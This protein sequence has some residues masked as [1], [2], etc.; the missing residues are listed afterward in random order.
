MIK[1]RFSVAMEQFY[2][3]CTAIHTKCVEILIVI[4]LFQKC[5]VHHTCLLYS[6]Y[7]AACRLFLGI[8]SRFLRA[9]Q[10]IRSTSK[11]SAAILLFDAS[12]SRRKTVNN[13]VSRYLV[14][15][16]VLPILPLTSMICD[17]EPIGGIYIDCEYAFTREMS[18]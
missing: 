8:F 13:S 7:Q 2:I 1:S 12:P 4:M 11:Q 14:A 16:S 3:L 15:L 10:L 6:I 5:L 18:S 9:V 17:A